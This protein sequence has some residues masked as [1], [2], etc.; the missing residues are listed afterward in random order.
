MRFKDLLEGAKVG[1]INLKRAACR[2]F[3]KTI[4]GIGKLLNDSTLEIKGYQIVIDNPVLKKRVDLTDSEKTSVQDT[5][6]VH[7]MCE[8]TRA[9]A[10]MQAK[11]YED[12][13]IDGIEDDINVFMDKLGEVL[14]EETLEEFFYSIDSSFVDDIHNTV[15]NYIASHIS[16]DSEEFVS[17]LNLPD[18]DREKKTKNY[19]DK[20]LKN[21]KKELEK[22]ANK[23]RMDIFH[24]IIND[25]DDCFSN[26]KKL[27]EEKQRIYKEM[28]QH[29]NDM[30]Y[31]K[32]EAINT[33]ADIDRMEA[34]RFLTYA[35]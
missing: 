29:R 19:V 8:E 22:K 6:D 1:A 20:V 26:E 33:I 32:K 11:C 9:Q 25:L 30:E 2:A 27:N 24:Q 4:E 28:E 13:I 5:I 23:K 35:V 15:S 17:I 31:C 7:R 18:A 3:G 16:V 14:T 10:A 34:I 12:D 21:A